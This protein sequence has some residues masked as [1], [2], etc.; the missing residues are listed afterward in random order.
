M[1]S[2]NPSKDVSFKAEGHKAAVVTPNLGLVTANIKPE[3][4]ST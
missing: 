4:V 2:S 1:E 3:D